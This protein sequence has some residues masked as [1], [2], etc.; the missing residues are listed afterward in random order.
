MDRL[1]EFG[2]ICLIVDT[3][4]IITLVVVVRFAGRRSDSGER[5]SIS[6]GGMIGVVLF[7]EFCALLVY[8]GI[9]MITTAGR[10]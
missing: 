5:Q 7:F 6:V 1:W 2:A 4:A 8:L 3:V 10:G 9:R